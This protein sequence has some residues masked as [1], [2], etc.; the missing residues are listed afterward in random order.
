LFLLF[1]ATEVAE[2]VT[3]ADRLPGNWIQF[4]GASF[5]LATCRMNV[6]LFPAP[7]WLSAIYL[8]LSLLGLASWKAETGLRL[9][10]TASAYV[11]AFAVVGQPFND[12]WGL[13]YAPLLPFGF[14]WSISAL[15]D[16]LR[17]ILRSHDV[18]N[19]SAVRAR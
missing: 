8:P 13:M 5:I 14:V 19:S 9:F 12:Y 11:A 3:P 7:L 2:R 4:G 16:L 18:L 17:S 6:F 10:L 1:H 15:R